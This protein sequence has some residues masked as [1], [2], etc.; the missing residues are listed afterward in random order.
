ME[1]QSQTIGNVQV[2]RIS[3]NFDA[4]NAISARKWFQDATTVHTPQIVVNLENVSFLDSTALSVLVQGMKRA[5]MGSGDVRLC[6][7]QQPVRM[8]FELTRLDRVF[9][10]FSSE[11][12]AIQAFLDESLKVS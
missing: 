8:V 2:L 7:M 10:I 9:E 4:Y 11:E 5:R 6:N 12:D 1:V 3:G